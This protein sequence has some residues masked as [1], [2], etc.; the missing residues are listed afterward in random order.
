MMTDPE[1]QQYVNP[2]YRKSLV[3]VPVPGKVF[4][5]E[6]NQLSGADPVRSDT[7]LK[8]LQDFLQLKKPLNSMIWYKPGRRHNDTRVEAELD[9]HKINI[10]D[11]EH[12]FLRGILMD[13]AVN[14]SRWIRKYFMR[15][16]DVVVASPDHL[17]EILQGWERDP[18]LDR[19]KKKK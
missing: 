7:F 3:P 5:Y 13:Q 11:E 2:Q 1:E 14:A 17:V 10:C 8:T 4:L 16:R 19:M 15:G 6:V 12:R 18:C 9:S